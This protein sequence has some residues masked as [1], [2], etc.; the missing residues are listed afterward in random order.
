MKTVLNKGE[1]E[2][3]TISIL[4]GVTSVLTVLFY[5]LFSVIKRF[6]QNDVLF[7]I[8]FILFISN[9]LILLKMLY[10]VFFRDYPIKKNSLIWLV[11]RIALNFF[12]VILV[13]SYLK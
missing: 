3:K 12:A 11:I 8:P 7:W 2:H 10:T 4:G 6:G 1:T 9:L 5:I 13:G